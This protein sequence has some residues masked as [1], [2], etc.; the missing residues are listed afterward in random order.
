MQFR[1]PEKAWTDP[2]SKPLRR[3]RRR[4]LFF[5][6][7][8]GTLIALGAGTW[9]AFQLVF[10]QATPHKAIFQ[11]A[12]ITIP[13]QQPSPL[14]QPSVVT[15]TCAD[16]PSGYDDALRQELAQALHLSVPQVAASLRARKSLQEIAAAQHISPDQLSG[17]ERYAYKVSDV[18]MVKGGCMSQ[19]TATKHPHERA[20]A[21]NHDFAL[22]YSLIH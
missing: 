10:K 17:I 1:E 7:L 9:L 2:Q 14:P 4:L 21:L 5:S 22:L 6:L 18:Q 8:L 11:K 12:G 20:S 15:I 3:S 13:T 16:Y 19:A